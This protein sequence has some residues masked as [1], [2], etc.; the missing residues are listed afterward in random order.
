MASAGAGSSETIHRSAAPRSKG[1]GL[2]HTHS[3]NMAIQAM[4]ASNTRRVMLR[5][6]GRSMA[7]SLVSKR[8]VI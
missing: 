2:S 1:S 4:S 5:G 7:G 8:A 3:A 6:R